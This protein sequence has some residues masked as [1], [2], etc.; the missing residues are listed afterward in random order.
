VRQNGLHAQ[1]E[2]MHILGKSTGVGVDNYVGPE[3]LQCCLWAR[4]MEGKQKC[5]YHS[6][7]NVPQKTKTKKN[8]D[9]P[10]VMDNNILSQNIGYISLHLWRS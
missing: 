10:T 3:V 6:T 4:G 7:V 5:P 2:R 1:K 8:R 9:S